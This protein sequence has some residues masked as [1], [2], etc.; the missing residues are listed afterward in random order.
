[1][2][3]G[4]HATKFNLIPTF[5]CLLVLLAINTISAEELFIEPIFEPV[6]TESD[7]V[8]KPDAMRVNGSTAEL[9]YDVYRPEQIA[10]GPGC[11]GDPSR[12]NP[13]S[14]R[15]VRKWEQEQSEHGRDGQIFRESRLCCVND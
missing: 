2:I 9:L 3:T 5:S 8:Y 13:D 12:L 4:M 11:T 1:M 6:I 14:R 10:G 7:Q 15:W